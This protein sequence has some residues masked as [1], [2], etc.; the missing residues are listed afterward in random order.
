MAIRAILLVALASLL[1][2][3]ILHA[4]DALKLP[5]SHVNPENAANQSSAVF[6]GKVTNDGVRG[7][8]FNIWYTEI[9]NLQ[10]TVLQILRGSSP[11][12][13]AI[14]LNVAGNETIPKAGNTYIFFV[15]QLIAL[16]LL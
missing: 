3:E 8:Y 10:V 9:S 11:N 13:I 7:P 14:S 15:K 2:T 4:D 12:H 16:K 1:F 5:G 6:V